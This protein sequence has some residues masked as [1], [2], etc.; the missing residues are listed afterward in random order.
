MRALDVLPDAG[1]AQKRLAS[2]TPT[3]R[4]IPPTPVPAPPRA[5]TPVPR[6]NYPPAQPVQPVQPAQPPPEFKPSSSPV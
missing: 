1:E 4:P 6:T 2:Y 3:P 5:P